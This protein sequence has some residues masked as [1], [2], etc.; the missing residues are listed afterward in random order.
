MEWVGVAQ[1]RQLINEDEFT[2][3]DRHLADVAVKALGLLACVRV[4]VIVATQ[5]HPHTANSSYISDDVLEALI[6]YNHNNN[7]ND[8]RRRRR[9]RRME[10]WIVH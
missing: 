10:I 8:K 5:H 3:V 1:L 6:H 4:D 2:V 9:R 7:K